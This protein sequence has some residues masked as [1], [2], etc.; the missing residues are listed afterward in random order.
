V[1]WDMGAYDGV[2][3]GETAGRGPEIIFRVVKSPITF[4]ASICAFG[5]LGYWYGRAHNWGWLTFFA[6][7]VVV[8]GVNFVAARRGWITANQ[9]GVDDESEKVGRC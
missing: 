9:R 4:I 3:E 6:G 5:Y 7:L 1:I 2:A 8:A